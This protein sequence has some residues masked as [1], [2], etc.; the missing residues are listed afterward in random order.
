MRRAH[1]LPIVAVLALQ[2]PLSAQS[3]RSGL[4]DLPEPQVDLAL[5]GVAPAA[6]GTPS[7]NEAAAPPGGPS[8]E[9]LTLQQAKDIALK[10]NPRISEAALLALAQKQIVREARSAESPS[11]FADV[12]AEKSEEGNRLSAG[13]LSV[14]RLLDHAGGGITFSQLITDFGHS[15]NL[16]ASSSLQAK[17]ADQN[18]MATRDEILLAVDIA[19]YRALE[20]RATLQ[21]AQSTVAARSSVNE[22]VSALTASKLRSTLDQSF[23]QVNLSQAQL[24]ALD[25]QNQAQAAVAALNELMG[26]TG[27]RAYRLI[28]NSGNPP[29][30]DGSADESVSR[31]LQQRPDLQAEHLLHD[32]DVRFARA[33]RDQLLPTVSTLGV[34]GGTPWAPNPPD[35]VY[36]VENWYGAVGVNVRVPI[37]NGF[38]FHAQAK[39]ADFRARASDER[40]RE[41]ADLIARDVRTAWLQATTAQQRMTV[42][43]QLVAQANT[44]LELAQTRYNLGLSSIVELSQAQLQQTQAQ[45]ADANARFEFEA[46]LATLRF[47]TGTQP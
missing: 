22:Q 8:G 4:P 1:L 5:A 21:V 15:R 36:F 38:R 44:A 42:T 3:L 17:A 2:M 25:A 41:L 31:A 45:I 40:S 39:E 47:Q 29:A 24:L 28:D 10:N 32:S 23:A 33:Q 11:V 30:L 16:V 26:S 14:S 34:L 6:E 27:D 19:F 9:T 13:S 46:D 20:A 37:F 7:Q 43:K 35:T 18:A 12:T